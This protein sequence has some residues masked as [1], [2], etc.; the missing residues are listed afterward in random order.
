V[1]AI[2]GQGTR[3]RLGGKFAELGPPA[4]GRRGPVFRALLD[5]AAGVGI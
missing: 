1:V 3:T 4:V 2:A 5:N